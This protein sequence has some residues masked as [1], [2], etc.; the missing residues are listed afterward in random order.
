MR[1]RR[2]L[3]G[4]LFALPVLAGCQFSFSVGGPDYGEL[5]SAIADELNTQYTSIDRRVSGVE[6]PRPASSPKAGESLTCEATL[7]GQAVRVGVT[8]TDDEY[9]VDF[10]TLDTVFDLSEL[11]DGLSRDVSEQVGFDV[12]VDCGSGI[13]IVPVGDD[14]D[15]EAADRRGD[16]RM[17]RVT[18]AGPGERDSWK[19]L[20]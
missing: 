18:A 16:T 1:P 10:E 12:T 17:V 6:C 14:F 7:E 4:T 11:A 20:D 2:A 15:C 13:G 5:E 19:L 9:N 3:Y 8:F